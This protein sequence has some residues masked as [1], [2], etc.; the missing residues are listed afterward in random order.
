MRKILDT[1]YASAKINNTLMSELK[2]D[3]PH[4]ILSEENQNE[5][6]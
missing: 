5:E 6:E 4:P 1:Y 2:L 3:E